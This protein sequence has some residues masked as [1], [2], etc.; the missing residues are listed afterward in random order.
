MVSREVLAELSPGDTGAVQELIDFV[1]LVS[2]KFVCTKCEA[3]ACLLIYLFNIW[4]ATHKCCD[5]RLCESKIAKS[6]VWWC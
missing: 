2:I 6:H 1:C 3:K 5:K 4:A